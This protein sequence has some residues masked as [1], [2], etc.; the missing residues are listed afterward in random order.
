MK[1]TT[2]VDLINLPTF[3]VGPPSEQ[4]NWKYNPRDL[5]EEVNAV[6]QLLPQLKEAGMSGEDLVTTFI[7]HRVSPLQRRVHKICHMSGPLN[8]TRMST[9]ELTKEAV[10]WRVKAIAMVQMSAEWEWGLEPH[11]RTN[12]PPAISNVKYLPT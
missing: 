7:S 11:S 1:N 12:L 4:H 8:P 5:I 6:H 3:I 2:K 9:F 10:R